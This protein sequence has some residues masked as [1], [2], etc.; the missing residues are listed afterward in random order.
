MAISSETYNKDLFNLL[1]TKGY[2][3]VPLDFKGDKTNPE[4]AVVFE[5]QFKKDG[6]RYGISYVTVDND[7]TVYYDDE[8]TDSPSSPTKDLDYDDTWSGFLQQMKH[9]AMNKQL[10]FDLSNKDR[11]GDDLAQRKYTMDKEKINEGYYPM[12][13]QQ[14]YSDAIPAVKIILQ[15]TRQIQ[16]GEQRYRNIA[17][18][19]LENQNGERFL[20][21]T[22]RPGIAQVYARH[23]AEGG[24]P[25]DE[26]WN[27]IKGLCEEYSKMAGFVRAVKNNQFN[28]SAQQ[29]VNEGI[30]HY[31]S[32][33]ETLGKMRGQR[34]YNTYFESWTPTLM[35]DESTENTINELFVQETL[36]PR[37]ESVLPILSK[38]HK[39][40]VEMKE[41]D[42]LAKW[43]DQLTEAPGAMTLQHNQNTEKS[44]LKAFDLDEDD[45]AVQAGQVARDK[46]KKPAFMRKAAGEKPATLGDVE[47]SQQHRSSQAMVGQKGE[48]VEESGLQAYL[49][50]KKYGKDGMDA[51][52]KAGRDGASKEKMAKI[53]AKYDK[54]DKEG[55]AEGWI[56]SL[57]DNTKNNEKENQLIEL[58]EIHSD[59]YK[60]S[61]GKRIKVDYRQSP[62][63]D[64]LPG[65]IKISYMDPRLK[66]SMS[67]GT[68]IDRPWD[69][70]P[71]NIKQ[72]I[73]QWVAKQPS[74]Q[75]VAEGYILKKTNVSKYMK[76]GDPDE[77]T[78]DVNV[79]DTDYEIINNKT[80]QVVGT[81]SWTTND[82]FG[83]GALKIT[84]KNGATRWLD[85][86][87]RE[88]GNPQSAFNRFVKD[89]KTAKKYK[90]EQ[91]VAEAGVKQLPTQG[92]DYSK[93][94]TDTLKMMLRPG[95]LHRNEARFKA[96][97]RKEL[98]K[99]EQQSQQGVAEGWND[100]LDDPDD[101]E[102]HLERLRDLA[103]L[104][105]MQDRE[106]ETTGQEDH[107]KK[108][109]DEVNPH[110]YDSDLDYYD[111]VRRS[112]LP[113]MP[114]PGDED[115]E[116]YDTFDK[117]YDDYDDDDKDLK[118]DVIESSLLEMDSEGYKG[119]RGNEDPGK[120]PEKVV[121]PAK[122][123]DVA[124]DAEKEL[125]KAM[126]KAHKKDVAEGSGSKY[127]V[128]SIGKDSK[129][130]YYISPSTGKKVYKSGVNKGDHENPKTGEIKKGVDEAKVLQ[131][132]QQSSLDRN[133]IV[134]LKS[135][136]KTRLELSW[137]GP[138]V[139]SA[140]QGQTAQMNKQE[141]ARLSQNVDKQL[142]ALGYEWSENEEDFDTLYLHS[143][144]REKW[145][146]SGKPM[147]KYRGLPDL[148]Y[149]A[150]TNTLSEYDLI[151]DEDSE[152]NSPKQFEGMS[153]DLDA[154]QKRVGQLGPTEPVGKNEKNLRG[155]LV[156]NESVEHDPL[157]DILRLSGK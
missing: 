131:F 29:L 45:D 80:G 58:F 126:D 101:Y 5:F 3:P 150:D 152:Y 83:P 38:L 79:K 54:L 75:G 102:G 17:K 88:K 9:W 93:Y 120:G 40:V 127:K 51:L 34:G 143:I 91:G 64:G 124:K 104:K 117:S 105:R 141:L 97:I 59:Y 114:R 56:D 129:G 136:A 132:P 7:V 144:A 151:G 42:E 116:K 22:T 154:N 77:Y 62:N 15:H 125:T 65:T 100:H 146:D 70:A 32:L 82:F 85:I 2:R 18:I 107:S 84:M 113:K 48:E 63:A 90:D 98:Q 138:N 135:L 67:S 13:K 53:R 121:K 25:N 130:D 128:K 50:N 14:S 156:G 6:E 10:G 139:P 110:Y 49:G 112:Q 27:H 61:D 11:L 148:M 133:L 87:E 57:L 123:K 26:R 12:G 68:S 72:A 140:W 55:V 30:N 20:A 92:A 8:Q 147:S 78:Q 106:K 66:P 89:P 35:E 94:D 145:Y 46:I 155:K 95:I 36:D 52:R 111:A 41:V 108:K 115:F 33:R 24:V 142:K 109:V 31:Q 74:Q 39:S 43:A 81:A 71:P 60:L 44:N 47:R 157:K 19:F 23:I 4:E 134:Q 119:H 37:I 103:D 137:E 28:E 99:R 16:E 118:E 73:Q 153:E 149:N 122:A 96:L 1:K 69:K 76:P 21:P 86:W